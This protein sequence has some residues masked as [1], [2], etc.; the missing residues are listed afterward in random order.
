MFES[1]VLPIVLVTV[2]GLLAGVMLVIAAKFMAVKTDERLAAVREVLP[3]AN[4]GACGFAGCDDYAA[5]LVKDGVAT[6]LC[7]PGGEA[8]SR[9]ISE[10]LG[11]EFADVVELR[12]IVKCSGDCDAT[13][14]IMNYEGRKTCIAANSFFQGRGTCS[15]AC[16]GYGDCVDVCQY[17]AIHIEN[18]V[19]VIDKTKCTGCG[20]CARECPNNLIE[21]VPSTSHIF[22][23]CS[24]KDKGAMTRKICRNGCI[25]CKKCEKACEVGAITVNDNL[26]HVDP[27]KCTNCRVCVSQCPTGVIK[28]CLK[29]LENVL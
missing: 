26:A 3:G 19:A 15:Y 9:K 16:L 13:H 11:V 12:G 22:V 29:P 2:I 28:D 10:V 1:F 21:M 27:A 18:G 23:A 20:M 14:Y 24:S 25:G 5:K 17:D 4:C 8:V 6:N 7:T